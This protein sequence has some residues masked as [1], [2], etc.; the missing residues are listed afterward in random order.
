LL[1]DLLIHT[2]PDTELRIESHLGDIQVEALRGPLEISTDLGSVAIRDHAAEQHLRI[3]SNNGN[4]DLFAESVEADTAIELSTRVGSITTELPD[5]IG[6]Q[7]D[8]STPA[9]EIQVGGYTFTEQNEAKQGAS[10]SLTA[11]VEPADG[12]TLTLKGGAGDILLRGR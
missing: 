7:L 10:H 8:A 12:R 4:I 1:V 2:P 5:G 11:L 6:F 3:E 9:G